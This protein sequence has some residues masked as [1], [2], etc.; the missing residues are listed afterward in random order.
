MTD[1][2]LVSRTYKQLMTLNSIKK[3]HSKKWTEDL[4]RH[5]SKED[6]QIAN[7][8]MKICSTALAIREMQ[9]KTT[10]KYHLTSVKITLIKKSTNN[11]CWRGCEEKGTLLHYWWEWKLVEPLLEQYGSSLKN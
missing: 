2:G 7:R 11:K 6:T 8:H 5:Y 1:K 3:T 10:M 9:I 4:S